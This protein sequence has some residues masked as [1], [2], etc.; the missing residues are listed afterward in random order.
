MLK[1]INEIGVSVITPLKSL[2][3]DVQHELRCIEG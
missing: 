1:P 3:V 2:G